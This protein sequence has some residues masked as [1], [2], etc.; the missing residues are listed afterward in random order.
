MANILAF[1]GSARSESVNQRVVDC[2]VELARDRGANV[3]TLD[4]RGLSIPLY[5]GDL[6]TAE[7]LPRGA[8][9]LREAMIGADGLIIGCPEYNGF[10]TPLLINAIDWASRAEGSRPDLT[11]FRDKVVLICSASPGGFGGM[12]A[13]GHLRTMLSGIGSFVLPQNLS[14]PSAHNAFS[15]ESD[16]ADEALASRAADLVDKFLDVTTRLG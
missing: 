11:P 2:L 3:T 6:E 16:F 12:R 7:G 9:E 8:A 5:D 1:C 14:V 10:I 4:L 15:A 13:A